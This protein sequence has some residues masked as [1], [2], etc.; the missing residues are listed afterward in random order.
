[1][2]QILHPFFQFLIESR[3]KLRRLPQRLRCFSYLYVYVASQIESLEHPGI[4]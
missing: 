2:L 1:M 3:H 4:A